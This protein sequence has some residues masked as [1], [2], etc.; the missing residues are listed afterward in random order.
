MNPEPNPVIPI[1]NQLAGRRI[2]GGCPHCNAYQE[3]EADPNHPA[4]FHCRIY[5]DD[6]CPDHGNDAPYKRQN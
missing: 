3:V 5:H 2:P 1:L 6:W 4:I